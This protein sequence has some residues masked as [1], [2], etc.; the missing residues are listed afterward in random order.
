MHIDQ[1][2][3]FK[4][5]SH[6]REY[7]RA[8]NATP[9]SFVKRMAIMSDL[10]FCFFSNIKRFVNLLIVIWGM[11]SSKISD[12]V[13]YKAMFQVLKGCPAFMHLCHALEQACL[14][15]PVVDWWGSATL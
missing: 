12:L 8:I 13:G 4:H 15:L 5:N 2:E 9:N 10:C 3:F 6:A 1:S 14:P 7:P 11:L